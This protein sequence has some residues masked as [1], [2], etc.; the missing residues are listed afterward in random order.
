[1][2][3]G[4]PVGGRRAVEG[5]RGDEE[6]EQVQRGRDDV[7]ADPAFGK[8]VPDPRLSATRASPP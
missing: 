2:L 1:M 3:L 7:F 5:G 4:G 8:Q 6:A